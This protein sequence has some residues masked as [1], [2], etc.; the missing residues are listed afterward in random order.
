LAGVRAATTFGGWDIHEP[1]DDESGVGE[2]REARHN[3]AAILLCDLTCRR[4][5]Y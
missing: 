2:S 4:S 3:P 1:P 5:S